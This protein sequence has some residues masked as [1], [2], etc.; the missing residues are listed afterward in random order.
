MK[1]LSGKT[2]FITGASRGIGREIALKCARA[3]ANIVIAAKSDEPHPK[4]PGTIHSVAEEVIAAGGQALANKVDV[5]DEDTVEAAMKQAADTFGGIDALINNAGAIRL[6]PAEQTPIK[7][8]DLMQSINT[9]AVLLCSQVALPY[10]KKSANGHI[11]NLSPPINLDLKWL[12]PFI[13]YTITKYGMSMLTLGLA[14]EFRDQN[15]AVN[16]LWP[17]TTVATA[18]VEFEAGA[19]M[20]AGSRTPAIMADAAYEILTTDSRELTGQLLLD[21][22]LL[23]ERGTTDF[24]QYQND[25]S[26]SDLHQDLYVD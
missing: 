2:I 15:I 1:N 24:V 25:S 11:I 10:L 17:Q 3:G 5:R 7:R 14:E 16:S 4:L 9:R 13:P 23:R 21:E 26:C 18:A 20:L 6:T 19:D 12:K 8:F 22:D